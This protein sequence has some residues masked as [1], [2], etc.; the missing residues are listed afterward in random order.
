MSLTSYRRRA[1]ALDDD[2][3]EYHGPYRSYDLVKEAT[4]ALGVVVLLTVVLSILFSSPDERSTTI[5]SWSRSAPVD[6]VTT[7]LSELD[8]TSDTATY[9]PPYNSASSGQ[10]V[11]FVHLA[12][13]FGIA[14]PINAAKDDVIDPLRSIANDPRLQAAVSRY[15]AASVHT[16]DV[17]VSAYARALQHASNTAAGVSAIAGAGAG[18]LPVMMRSELT[19]AQ[20]GGLDG[21]LLTSRQFYSTDYTKI[22]MFLADGGFLASR[23]QAE[24]LLGTQWGMMNETGSYPGQGWL[25]LYTFWYQVKPFST[26]ANADILVMV[27]MGVMSLAFVLVPFIPG[28]RD[29]PRALP[30]YR[31]IWREHYRHSAKV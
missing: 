14:H 21:A 19:F 2:A 15:Q 31:L 6:F 28:V 23:A 30:V 9:G 29:L 7:A 18:P 26:S 11:L 4:V 13:W 20:S 27:V 5:Q 16:R 22:L 8:G 17:W 25:W 10:H 1:R 12:K 3:R 24:H